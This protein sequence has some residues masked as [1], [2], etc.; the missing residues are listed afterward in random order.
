METV[1][2]SG[3]VLSVHWGV[4]ILASQPYKLHLLNLHTWG[5]GGGG[6]EGGEGAERLQVLHLKYLMS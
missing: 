4:D 1:R 3:S 6:G 5:G 2:P